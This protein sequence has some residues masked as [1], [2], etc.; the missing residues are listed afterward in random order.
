MENETSTRR[1]NIVFVLTDDQGYGDLACHGNP[2]IQTPNL[3]R[4]YAESIHFTNYH[5]GPTCAPTRAGL[6]TGHY[7]NSTGVWHTIGGRSLLRDSER[8]IADYLGDAGYATGLFGKWHLGDA[9]PYRPQDHGFG[10]VVTHGGGGIGNTPD[11]WENNYIDDY[12]CRDGKWERFEGYCTDVWFSL[13]IDFITR[14]R[15]E[16][17]YCYVTPNAPHLPHIVPEEY[18][19]PYF[20]LAKSDPAAAQFFNYPASDQMIKFYGMVTCIDHNLGRL[21]AKLAELGLADNTIFCFMTD[22]GSAGGL[23]IDANRFVVHGYN[24]GMRGKKATPYE[25]GHRV[26]LFLHWPGGGLAQSRDI[27][28]LS[29]NVDTTPTLLALAGV[30]AEPSAFHGRS[31]VPLFEEKAEAWPDRA[32]VTDS[33][34]LL[35]PLKWRLSSTMRGN[36]RLINGQE[37]YDLDIDFEQ[38]HDRA[39]EH[40]DIVEKLRGDYEEW[41][42]LV[43]RRFD[44]E[45]P[46]RIGGAELVVAL[47]SHDWRR[48]KA[49]HEP[50]IGIA[51][52]AD[53][54]RAVWNQSQVRQGPEIIGYWEVDIAR[55]GAYRFELRRW[56]RQANL[57]LTA[58]IAGELKPYNDSIATGYGGG[59]AIEIEQATIRVS[60]VEATQPVVSED[61]AVT[62]EL[63]LPAGQSH[64][65]T[66]FTTR[67][68]AQLA[69]YY[70]YAKWVG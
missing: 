69:A 51:D 37:L 25:G 9:Y 19:Q 61:T 40:P 57:P 56:P 58:G 3:D 46:I 68:G 62:F 36:W 38:R 55:A 23:E 67:E 66:F 5:C 15:D 35:L 7:A 16:Q 45:I 32:I 52:Y 24:A 59:R 14:H 17:F 43:S 31:L 13:A 27:S 64:L 70:V 63:T 12:Y 33:Q 11:H 42:R 44:E 54:V 26:P 6:L 1:P 2:Y 60:G 20:A 4:L 29:A 47:T 50:A 28:T 39:S 30:A 18:S 10:E 53:D 8:T 21:R 48:L 65:E 41:W 34:R 22:N 49:E